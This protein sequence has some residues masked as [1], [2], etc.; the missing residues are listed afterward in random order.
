MLGLV[1][2]TSARYTLVIASALVIIV[3]SLR[4]R[5]W[6]GEAVWT[7]DWFGLT[8]FI[9]GP[10]V[11]AMTAL[12][13][14]RLA[15]DRRRVLNSTY[16]RG[17]LLGPTIASSHALAAAIPALAATFIALT[18]YDA[19]IRTSAVPGMLLMLA[20]QM[21]GYLLYASLGYAVGLFCNAVLA[22]VI[23]GG[24]GYAL[25]YF[26]S[27]AAEGSLGLLY[28]GGAT[29]SRLGL[30][31]NYGHLAVQMVILIGLSALLL[32]VRPRVDTETV[33]PTWPGWIALTLVGFVL[34][35]A[36]SLEVGN[37]YRVLA[38]EPE[39]CAPVEDVQFCMFAEGVPTFNE[40]RDRLG[41][42]VADLKVRGYDAML[43]SLVTQRL[44][45]QR[46]DP[47]QTTVDFWQIRSTD[48]RDRP[49]AWA[50]ELYTPYWCAALYGATP[51]PERYF[52][53]L[54]LLVETAVNPGSPNGPGLSPD[55][56]HELLT[57]WEGCDL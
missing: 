33:L 3:A 35:T 49:H 25:M 57:R 26:Q 7:V 45:G 18:V 5:P 41:V 19:P 13:S 51:P 46:P 53:D 9:L 42:L 54:T 55:E 23:G 27:V 48:E 56:A 29:V 30:T 44:R 36:P 10:I 31:V 20:A 32:L 34:A 40:E 2:L 38:M 14:S 24:V 4:G 12:D 21:V 50:E 8:S 28:L 11:T 1:R 52:D 6:A 39:A 47:G 37:R 15:G 22:M 16:Q 43:P 17:H